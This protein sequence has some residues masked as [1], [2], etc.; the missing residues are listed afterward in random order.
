MKSKAKVAGT[1]IVLAV[2][3]AFGFLSWNERSQ[4]AKTAQSRITVGPDG[5][6][7][8]LRND[9]WAAVCTFAYASTLTNTVPPITNL[10]GNK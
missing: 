4:A 2:I 9:A 8:F 1:C 5:K 7:V 3:T 6:L 10:P